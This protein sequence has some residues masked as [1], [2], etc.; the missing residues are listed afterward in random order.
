M[1]EGRES[2]SGKPCPALGFKRGGKD[3]GGERKSRHWTGL[4]R[5]LQS[6][7][8][9]TLDL[10]SWKENQKALGSILPVSGL[11]R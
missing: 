9:Q 10:K 5:C 4:A 3:G 2:S 11:S 7:T 6:S 1:V 8:R